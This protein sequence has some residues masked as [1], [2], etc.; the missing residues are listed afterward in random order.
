VCIEKVKVFNSNNQESDKFSFGEEMRIRLEFKT[1]R[2]IES[3]VFWIGIMNDNEI[4]IAGTYYNKDRIG[5]YMVEGKM[6]LECI[7]NSL[8]L[9]PGIYHLMVGAYDEYGLIAYDRIGRAHTFKVDSDYSNGFENYKGYG[10][11]GMVDFAN[12]WKMVT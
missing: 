10:A 12:E 6:A 11:D 9:R 3:P 5:P 1:D 4:K 2:K 7:F 8:S